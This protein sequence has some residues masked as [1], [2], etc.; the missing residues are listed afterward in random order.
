MFIEDYNFPILKT[1]FHGRTLLHLASFEENK[2][3]VIYLVEHCSALLNIADK[4]GRTVINY[5]KNENM[6]QY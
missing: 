5:G 1:D 3:L 6:K 2:D 4:Y